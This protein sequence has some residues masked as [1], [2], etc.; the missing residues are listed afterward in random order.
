MIP[1][2]TMVDEAIDFIKCHEPEEGY[3][4][5]FSGGK[6]SIV[7]YELVKMAGVKHQVFYSFTG[8]DS[9]ELVRFIRK[10]YP[11]VTFLHPKMSFWDGIKKKT[12]PLRTSRWCCDV[13]KKNPS[14]KIKLN[15]RIMGIRAEESRKRAERPRVQPYTGSKWVIYKPI[16]S[17]LQWHVWDFIEL[18]GLSYPS[19]YDEG[20]DRLGCVICPF[21][22]LK[23]MKLSRERWPKF[24]EKFERTVHKWFIDGDYA[25]SPTAKKFNIRTPDQYLDF[26]YGRQ[27][28]AFKDTNVCC[29]VLT[30]FEE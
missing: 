3:F 27:K 20:F 29:R 11:E 2:E 13:L 1:V 26:W 17:W 18:H 5:G 14:K 21:L 8:I 6:D 10:N 9:P 25:H 30:P 7:T 12:P 15:H 19:L 28:E 4:V 16:F 24:Y 23:K 22:T